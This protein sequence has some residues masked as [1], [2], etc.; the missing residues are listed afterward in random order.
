[1]LGQIHQHERREFPDCFLRTCLA[2][3]A[4]G[5]PAA[6]EEGQGDDLA[7]NHRRDRGHETDQGTGV[8]TG[9]QPG[10]QCA[11]ERQVGGVILQDHAAGHA[12]HDRHTDRQGEDQPIDPAA[13]LE[14]Q[15]VTEPVVPRQH[16]RQHRDCSQ[17]DKERQEKLLRGQQPGFHWGHCTHGLG[18]GSWELI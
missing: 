3:A 5:E 10:E 12:G 17:P 4:A 18:V 16:G 13:A 14:D 9:N 11:F 1:M 8:R 15:D 7:G 2:Q 6:N